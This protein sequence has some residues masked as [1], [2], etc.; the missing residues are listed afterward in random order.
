MSKQEEPL[1]FET[2][3]EHISDI[4]ESRLGQEWNIV[5]WVNVE[6][7]K[8]ACRVPPGIFQVGEKVRISV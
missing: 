5:A 7:V 2:E 1:F 3:I 6:G 4:S 8:R